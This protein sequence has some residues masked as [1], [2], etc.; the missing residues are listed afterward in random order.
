MSW[1]VVHVELRAGL[2]QARTIGKGIDACVAQMID[3]IELPCDSALAVLPLGAQHMVLVVSYWE[4]ASGAPDTYYTEEHV[5]DLQWQDIALEVHKVTAAPFGGPIAVVRDEEA[6]VEV[7]GSVGGGGR[8]LVRVFTSSGQLTGSFLWEGSRLADWGWSNELQLIMVDSQAKVYFY[9]LLGVREPKQVS[10][11]SELEREGVGHTVVYPDG[12]VVMGRQSGQLW[13]VVLVAVGE[14]VWVVDDHGATDQLLPAGC[15]GVSAMTVSPNGAFLALACHDGKLRVMSSDFG[16]QLSEFDTR[17]NVP[18]A[19]MAWCG[20]DAVAMRWEGLLLLVGPYGDW[21][22]RAA[23]G[24][25]VM[26]PEVDGVRLIGSSGT[27]GTSTSLLRRVPNVLLQVYKPGSTAP[28]AQLL[29]AADLFDA[30]SARSDKLLRQMSGQLQAAVE[31]CAT[32]AGLELS[33]PRQRALLRAAVFGRAFALDVPADLLHQLAIKMRILNAL[34]EPDVGLPLSMPQLEALSLPVVISRLVLYRQYLLAYR[35]AELLGGAGR[36]EVLLHWAAAKIS[37]NPNM[38]DGALREAI[39][40]KMSKLD[41]PKYAALAA[42][43]QSIGRRSLAIKLLE[44]EPSAA[45][46]VP[47]LISLARTTATTA[48]LP[49]TSTSTADSS[50]SACGED[51]LGRALRKAVEAGDPDLVY[52]ALFAAYRSR[53]LPEF[54][55]LVSPRA[56]AKNLFVKFTRLKEPELLETLYVTQQMHIEAADLA[57]ESALRSL[58]AA[59][60]PGGSLQPLLSSASGGAGRGDDASLNKCISGLQEASQKY[61]QSREMSWQSKASAEAALLLKEQLRLEKDTGQALFVGLSLTDTLTAC[62]KLNQPPHTRAITALR[63]AFS[64]PEARWYWI[65]LRALG[66]T[67]DWLA[68]ELFAAERKVSPIGWEPFLQVAAQNGAPQEVQARLISHMPDSRAKA[69]A[70]EGIGCPREAAE[71]AAKLRDGALFARI[72]DA[73]N[74]STPAGIAIAQIKERFQ[75]SFR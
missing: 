41:R 27:T 54:W 20:V 70:Y 5:Y 40:A 35:I 24:A 68:L 19:S 11:G 29:N 53:S 71:V 39:A 16:Q 45:Q 12:L 66:A 8:P 74:P 61:A 18:P 55:R 3:W 48:G 51:T 49:G 69:A 63:K 59:I 10:F 33:V 28:A 13:A 42:H 67:H 31:A 17:S 1:V 2:L 50:E 21:L 32:A 72:Q 75:S 73:I 36:D 57:L 62:I 34:R 30:G 4:A 64:V 44:E 52:L 15:G 47:L 60:A 37:A 22:R 25:L 6:L 23:T 58:S 26:V 7:R 65:K 14:T 46:Q 43:A 9:S 56:T 38:P